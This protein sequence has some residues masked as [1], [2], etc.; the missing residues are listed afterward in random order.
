M[1]KIYEFKTMRDETFGTGAVRE[2]LEIWEETMR[3]FSEFTNV[4]ERE[5]NTYEEA[6]K[7]LLKY[8][9]E[10]RKTIP[11]SENLT[12]EPGKYMIGKVLGKPE[13]N[14]Q[15]LRKVI[16]SDIPE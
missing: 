1:W 6:E 8:Y 10:C 13:K 4:E 14:L 3:F 15:H 16:G 9:E 7:Y 2:R 5:F 11:G 12:L